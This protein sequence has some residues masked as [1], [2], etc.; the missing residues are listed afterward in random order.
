VNRCGGG[1]D[2]LLANAALVEKVA[3]IAATD[4]A[5]VVVVRPICPWRLVA[6]A[7]RSSSTDPAA[8]RFNFSGLLRCR[9]AEAMRQSSIDRGTCVGI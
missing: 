6:A 9:G 5:A 1:G 7:S 2:I 8:A 4:A 3:V